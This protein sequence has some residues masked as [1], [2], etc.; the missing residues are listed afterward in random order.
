MVPL[1]PLGQ[2]FRAQELLLDEAERVSFEAWLPHAD[3]TSFL[4]AT[5]ERL[6]GDGGNNARMLMGPIA[7]DVDMDNTGS[8]R[9]GS[10]QVGPA[11]MT[12]ERIFVDGK[13]R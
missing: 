4:T 6:D 13:A 8:V 3:P 9:S 11:L 1:S 2:Q 12:I 7:M 10:I 5:I